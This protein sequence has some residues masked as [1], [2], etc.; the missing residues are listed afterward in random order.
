MCAENF[1]I[2]CQHWPFSFHSH[3]EGEGAV[4]RGRGGGLNRVWGSAPLEKFP[5]G[6]RMSFSSLGSLHYY[7]K[8]LPGLA[9]LLYPLK[10]FKLIWSAGNPQAL[11]LL[12]VF[13]LKASKPKTIYTCNEPCNLARYWTLLS[14]LLGLLA[15][16]CRYKIILIYI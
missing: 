6:W 3:S 4:G 9:T 5:S 11:Y 13:L 15:T 8:F 2:M 7:G 10:T 12:G 14:W 16:I 1:D